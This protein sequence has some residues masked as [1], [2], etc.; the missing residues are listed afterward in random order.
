MTKRLWTLLIALPVLGLFYVLGFTDWMKPV[1]IEIQ[2]SVRTIL[3][4][5]AYS[6]AEHEFAGVY[7]VIFN[8]DG[9]Y[10]LTE[11]WVEEAT[12]AAGQ[13]PRVLWHLQSKKGSHP[14]KTLLFGRDLENMD[15]APGSPNPSFA[16]QPDKPYR[17]VM[18][19]GRRKGEATFSTRAIAD[20]R[21]NF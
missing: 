17:V 8:L 10:S 19:A 7:P 1:P 15:P 6:T 4:K 11:I 14:V 12:P 20:L 9:S 13:T 3:P 2:T 18:K 16:L 5:K 21:P